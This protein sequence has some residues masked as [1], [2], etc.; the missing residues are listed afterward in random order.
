[1]DTR[2]IQRSDAMLLQGTSRTHENNIMLD[3]AWMQIRLP[4]K[5][6]TLK[7]TKS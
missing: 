7:R 4:V 5:D 1:M 6:D 3:Q 2:G